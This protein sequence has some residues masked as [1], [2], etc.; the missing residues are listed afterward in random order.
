MISFGQSAVLFC[1]VAAAGCDGA[2]WIEAAVE[3][4]RLIGGLEGC[5]QFGCLDE[6]GKVLHL[7]ESWGLS[8]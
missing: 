7:C 8:K 4:C 6:I 3:D 5:E 1:A 2:S